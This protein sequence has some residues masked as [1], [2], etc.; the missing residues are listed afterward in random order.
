M[1]SSRSMELAV[2]KLRKI[3][4]AMEYNDRDDDGVD[5]M[6]RSINRCTKHAQIISLYTNMGFDSTAFTQ[7]EWMEKI[8]DLFPNFTQSWVADAQN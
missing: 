5:G 1:Q 8:P 2:E 7:L 4:A 6:H 3:Q